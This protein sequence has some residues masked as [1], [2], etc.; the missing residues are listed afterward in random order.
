[1]SEE[2]PSGSASPRTGAQAKTAVGEDKGGKLSLPVPTSAGP[3]KG[4][5]KG[6]TP[7]AAGQ[8]SRRTPKGSRPP[9]SRSS[10]AASRQK[11]DSKTYVALS[12]RK[13]GASSR[14]QA[15]TPTREPTGGG[16]L[17]SVAEGREAAAL[18]TASDPTAALATNAAASSPFTW[19]IF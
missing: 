14:E 19:H 1:M 3:T 17:G 18:S 16:A 6:P 7:R 2:N 5:A 15:S 10:P 8:S 12:D 13:E 4:D 11:R 9:S